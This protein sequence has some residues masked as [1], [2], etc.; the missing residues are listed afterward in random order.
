MLFGE[1]EIV[2][3]PFLY[4]DDTVDTAI[5]IFRK[6]PYSTLPVT[7][8]QGKY[9]GLLTIKDII[10]VDEKS[11]TQ[12]IL[13]RCNYIAPLKN[14][15]EAPD[16]LNKGHLCITPVVDCDNNFLGY[17]SRKQLIDNICEKY[18]EIG[19][20]FCQVVDSS[21]NGIVAINE[22]GNIIVFNPSAERILG[23]KRTE[24][25]GKH[26]S[27]LDPS[28]GLLETLEKGTV[29]SGIKTCLNERSI[30]TNRTPL[31]H[32]NRIVGAM[33]IFTDISELEKL[34]NEVKVDKALVRELN[35]ILES[36]YDGLYICDRYGRV[37]RVNTAWERICG[38]SREEI[39][40]NTAYQLVA[41]GYYSKSAATEAIRTKKT[42]TVMLEMTAGPK[43]GQKIMATSTPIF[44]DQG[45]IEQVVVNVRDI[46]EIQELKNQLEAS[47]ELSKKYASELEEIRRQQLKID[48]MVAQS[49]A[50]Q[51]ILELVVRVAQV[52]STVLITGQSGVGKEVVAKKIHSLS[53]RQNKSL[54]KINCGA[55]P[56]NLLESELFGYE[57]GAFTGA[58]KEGKPGMIELA[59]GG[60]L[61]LDEI[62]ELPFSLQ[63]KL[64]RTLQ[65]REIYHV[66]GIK[67][68]PVDVRIIAA[69]NKDLAGMVRRGAFREDLFYRLNVLNIRIPPLRERLEDLPPLLHSIL[70]KY[71]KKYNQKKK[72][73]QEVVNILL[74]Y[75]WPG[76]IR[77]VEN[78]IERLVVMT[79]EDVIEVRHL[80]ESLQGISNSNNNVNI[81]KVI[82]LKKAVEELEL[83]LLELALKECG[84]TRKIAKILG[85]NQSTVVRKLQ[86]YR[87]GKADA[88]EHHDEV[89]VHHL[90]V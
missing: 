72:L 64:L 25:L 45:E 88:G 60:T 35:A 43:K 23:I 24:C 80:P 18:K 59:S 47:M 57:G 77:E 19:E 51:R 22:K 41:D 38:F 61:F 40:G 4:G 86:H 68:I 74:N 63:V 85:I 48:D 2:K 55:I 67:P 90:R 83:R 17:F 62:G 16:L 53:K 31:L 21:Y 70:L 44:D 87:I 29:T 37:T 84:S 76:N 30:L 50:M 69:T 15:E 65:D 26:I 20:Q 73:A 81:M 58:K 27:A 34:A 1:F 71:N 14:I 54:I 56:E 11:K 6:T 28:M 79:Q 52:D 3:E 82:P 78:L 39:V 32:N 66:G 5:S 75:E 13:S 12:Q 36:S 46:T 10:A 49:P 8:R 42:C 7:D 89:W 33:G 9:L